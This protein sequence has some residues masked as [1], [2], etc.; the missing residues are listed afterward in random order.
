MHSILQCM[1]EDDYTKGMI[2]PFIQTP[3]PEIWKLIFLS[4]I[5]PN[6]LVIK[7]PQTNLNFLFYLFSILMFTI[8]I[9][10]QTDLI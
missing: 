1:L 5:E 6:S 4:N 8:A 10:A 3:K 2:V 9:N 7:S